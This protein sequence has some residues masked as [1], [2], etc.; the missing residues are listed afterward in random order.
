MNLQNIQNLTKLQK[1]DLLVAT[2]NLATEERKITLLLIEH[3]RE[4]ERRML[5]AELGYGSLFEFS[6][7]YLGLSEGSAHR[8]IASMR[9]MRDV[10]T[11]RQDLESGSLSLSNAAK[12]HMAFNKEKHLS[13]QSKTKIIGQCKNTTQS[14]CERKLFQLLPAFEKHQKSER[15]R[16]INESEVELKLVLNT[17][18]Q[19]K[20]NKLKNLIAHAV[21]TNSTLDLI[22]YL[23]NKELKV[24]ERKYGIHSE[25]QNETRAKSEMEPKSKS[26]QLRST[27]VRFVQRLNPG[28]CFEVEKS[29]N[30]EMITNNGVSTNLGVPTRK[31]IASTKEVWKRANAKC[32]FPNCQSNYKLEIDHMQPK[33]LGG[34]N[35]VSNLRLLC[36]THNVQQ[37]AQ[38]LG[39][40]IMGRYIKSLNLE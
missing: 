22:E 39:T 30:H 27:Q 14:E 40:A 5:F 6:V 36:R 32:E 15:E 2:K 18:L 8:R 16:I 21:P 35:E 31:R 23:V 7:K 1:S 26:T 24:Q 38:K 28:W 19:A 10:P 34:T 3:L 17:A 9:L 25:V 12:L 4:I 20:I 37:A 29:G 11:V 33:S 13:I